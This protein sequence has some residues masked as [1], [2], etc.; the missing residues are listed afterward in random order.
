M[1]TK[2]TTR[3]PMGG[4]HQFCIGRCMKCNISK[5]DYE[6]EKKRVRQEQDKNREAKAIDAS[7]GKAEA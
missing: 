7:K 6:A 4:Y 3:C 1:T 2:P 5:R